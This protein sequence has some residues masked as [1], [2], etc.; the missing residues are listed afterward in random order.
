MS[1]YQWNEERDMYDKM[2]WCSCPECDIVFFN[3]EEFVAHSQRCVYG[4]QG[5]DMHKPKFTWR[6]S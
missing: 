1:D 5:V 3:W 6:V 2:G 4:E